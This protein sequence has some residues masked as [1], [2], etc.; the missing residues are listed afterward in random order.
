MGMI[1]SPHDKVSN[2]CAGTQS[3]EDLATS[4]AV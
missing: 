4:R 1:N 2:I 3:L